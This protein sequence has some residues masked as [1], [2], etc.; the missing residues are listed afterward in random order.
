MCIRD[1]TETDRQTDRRETDRQT[2]R[3]TGRQTDRQTEAKAETETEFCCCNTM[4][5]DNEDP[6]FLLLFLSWGN[7]HLPLF[8][9][10][11]FV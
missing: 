6:F 5:L 11:F 7:R 8:S 1:R 9:V 3:Q 4:N 10:L 2:D